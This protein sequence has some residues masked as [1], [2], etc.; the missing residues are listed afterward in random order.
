MKYLDQEPI[1]EN[2]K[3]LIAKD[4]INNLVIF[5]DSN[6]DNLSYCKGIKKIN[7]KEHY[8]KDVEIV[9]IEQNAILNKYSKN[10]KVFIMNSIIKNEL[11]KDFVDKNKSICFSEVMN[12]NKITP[13]PDAIVDTIKYYYKNDDLSGLVFTVA[14]RSELIG[15]PLINK[16]IDLNGTVN[17]IHTKTDDDIREKYFKEADCIITAAGRPNTFYLNHNIKKQLIIDAG[18]NVVNGKVC[19]DWCIDKINAFENITITKNPGGIGKLTTYELFK[20]T[21]N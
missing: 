20:E 14:N 10:Y 5:T 1:I 4:T 2:I 16:L 7:D 6:L 21:L 8:Y 17:V 3:N 11:V 19:G 18:I 9:D 13:T 12:C 15:K